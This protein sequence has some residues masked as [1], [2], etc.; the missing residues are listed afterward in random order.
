[1]HRCAS[2]QLDLTEGL[3]QAILCLLLIINILYTAMGYMLG[4]TDPVPLI[5]GLF[6]TPVCLF[7]APHI[8]RSSSAVRRALLVLLAVYFNLRIGTVMLS[9]SY[10]PITVKQGHP[11][12]YAPSLNQLSAKKNVLTQL[13]PQAMGRTAGR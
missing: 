7:A 1:M 8:P 5:V 13:L 2:S 3:F 10:H 6:V 12:P 4:Q 9:E 11:Q